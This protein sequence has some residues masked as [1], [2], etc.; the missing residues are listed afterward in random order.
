[1]TYDILSMTLDMTGIYYGSALRWGVR[2]AIGP[3]QY[4][5]YVLVTDEEDTF[6]VLEAQLRIAR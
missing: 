1:M 3:A 2:R 6:E 4:M 5:G